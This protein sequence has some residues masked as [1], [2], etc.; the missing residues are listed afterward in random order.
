MERPENLGYP[1]N[2]VE[3][4][5]SLFVASDGVTAYYASDRADSRGGLDL[6]K[7]ELNKEAQPAKTLYV[8]GYVTD[9]ATGKGLPSAVELADD[10]NEQII[11]KVQTDGTGFY[12]ITLPVGKDYTFTV[13]RK[14]YLFYSDVY[15]LSKEMPD[16]TYQKDI[17]L[18][19][20]QLNASVIF[21]NIQFQT[22]SFQLE[23]VSLIELS[24]L[25]QL[26]NENPTIKVQVNGH[27]DNVGTP[28]ANLSL[29]T[30][31]AKAVVDYLVSKGIDAKRLQY[32]GF[33]A[34]KPIA[35]NST[36]EG[37]A[38]NRRTEFVITGL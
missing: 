20:I 8:K 32:K 6:Y 16:S 36:D 27:T 11:N 25:L 26:M 15:A 17:Q 33:G 10:S 21:K 19:P 12:F 1:I 38:Q 9:A 34:T 29:S 22:N 35:D 18:Q 2:T 13:N 3:N 7:F 28:A 23:P 30:N 31:R 37:K 4:E 5:G 14:G 24:K